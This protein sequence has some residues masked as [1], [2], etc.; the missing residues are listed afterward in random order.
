[1]NL[2]QI[3]HELA[4]LRDAADR[5]GETLLDFEL[6]ETRTLLDTLP[7]EGTSAETWTATRADVARLWQ[8]HGLLAAHVQRAEK[9]RGK[10]ATLRPDQA[11]ALEELLT[12]PSLELPGESVPV[13]ERQLLG[14]RQATSACRPDELLARMTAT[15]GSATAV[16]ARFA[17]AWD[18]GP[19]VTAVQRSLAEA[20]ELSAAVGD[21]AG[22]FAPLDSRRL[23]LEQTLARDPL[24]VTETEV[25]QLEESVRRAC[26]DLAELAELRASSRARLVAARVLFDEVTRVEVEGETAYRDLLGKIADPHAVDPPRAA[27]SLGRQLEVVDELARAGEWRQFGEALA[28]WTSRAESL[29]AQAQAA[30]AANRAPLDERNELRGR[31]DGYRAKA[32]AL[33]L[34][35]DDELSRM[36]GSLERVLYTAPADLERA[37]RLIRDCARRLVEASHRLEVPA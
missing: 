4:R 33:G 3:D 18:L 13:G 9:L 11:A 17:D 14:G 1:M 21:G 7:L 29:L 23:A 35:E 20:S 6:E 19:R 15:F 5:I 10:R 8:W 2:D 16:V 25:A 12:G 26:A 37:N 32:T 27:N 22:H 34:A 30:A 24:L 28:G 36:F 31:L